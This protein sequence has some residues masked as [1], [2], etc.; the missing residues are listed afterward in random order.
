MQ[1]I[2]SLFASLKAFLA[3]SLN[4]PEHQLCEVLEAMKPCQRMLFDIV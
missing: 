3:K 2:L 4:L 1:Q